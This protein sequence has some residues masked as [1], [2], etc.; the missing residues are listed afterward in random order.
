MFAVLLTVGLLAQSPSPVKSIT[1]MPAV[2]GEIDLGTLK[3]SARQLGWSPD[4]T[5]L[6]LQTIELNRDGSVKATHHYLLSTQS[7]AAK[8]IAAQPDWAADYWLWKSNRWA[9]DDQAF[10]IEMETTKK[11]AS[12]T[13]TP[14]AG[15]LAKGGNVDP[16][17]GTTMESAVS[18]SQQSQLLNVYTLRL[19]GEVVGEWTNER[20]VPGLTFG[21]GPKGS[22]LIAFADK[23]GGGLVV[24]DKSGAKKKVD[25]TK[26][27]LLPAWTADG[28]RLAYLQNRGHNKYAVVIA[29][30]SR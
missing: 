24:M 16:T 11:T 28:T 13:A 9:P 20:P 25:G 17:T 19:K 30:V 8:T 14:M 5:E 29:G 23:N 26:D 1:V 3:G 6:Y 22:N 2:V 21:W 15:D 12:A 18:A 10:A 7:G 4:G 27:V